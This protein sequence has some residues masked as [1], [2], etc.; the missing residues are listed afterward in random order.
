MQ[1]LLLALTLSLSFL[2]PELHAKDPFWDL[3]TVLPERD[4]LVSSGIAQGKELKPNSV[5]ALIWNIKKAK[6]KKWPSEFQSYTRGKDLVLLQEAY[7]SDLFHTTLSRIKG[8]RW[9]LGISFL[10]KRKNDLPTG[11]MVGS[12]VKPIE[13]IVRHSPDFEPLTNTPKSITIARYGIKDAMVDLLVISVHAINFTSTGAFKRHIDRAVE[14]IRS[15]QGPV[16]FAGDF[17]TWN[18]ARTQYL[19]RVCK[20]LGLKDV[21]FKNG[22]QR[23]KFGKYYLDHTFVRGAKIKNAEV[24][25]FSEGS[26]HRPMVLELQL[27]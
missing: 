26:D 20:E 13:T 9:D 19:F 17:N 18:K 25:S 7:G 11:T 8:F 12:N 15:H 24:L 22:G 14:E 10:Y 4:S 3:F 21:V 5:R 27:L 1:K 2:A 16:L 23:L 6:L